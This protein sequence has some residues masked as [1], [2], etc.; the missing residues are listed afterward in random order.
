MPEDGRGGGDRAVAI[1]VSILLAVLGFLPVSSWIRGG[2]ADRAYGSRLIEWGYGT[3]ICLGLAI[4]AAIVLHDRGNL[5]VGSINR[6]RLHAVVRLA[7]WLIAAASLG[8]YSW[9]AVTVFQGR[10]L[11]IDEI[12]QVFQAR[13]FAA[14]RITLPVATHREFFSALNIVDVG[15]RMYSQFPPGGP[16]MLALGEL[17]HATWLVGPVCGAI[18]VLLFAHV[19]RFADPLASPLFR[20]GSTLLFAVAPFGAFMF[21]SHMNHGTALMWLLLAVVAL[22]QV[23]RGSAS[24]ARGARECWAFTC[25]FGLGAAAAIRP[26]DAFAFALPAAVWLLTRAI[27]NRREVLPL[28]V[29]G[30]GVAIPFMAMAAVNVASTGSPFLFG[31]EVLWGSAHGLGFHSAPWGVEHTPLRGIELIS[32]YVTRLQTFLFETPF[33]SLLPAILSLAL[34]RR[35]SA[36]DRYLLASALFLGGLYFAYWHDGFYLG[37]RFVFAWLPVLVLFTARLPRLVS[38]RYG[39]G[40]L[41]TGTTAVLVAGALIAMTTSLPIRVAQYRAVL[42]SMRTDYSAEASRAGVHDALVFVRESWG[43]QLTARMWARGI[44][45]SAAAS[46]YQHIDACVLDRAIRALELDRIRGHAAELRMV[47]LQRDSTRVRPSPLSPD[48]TEM[49]LPGAPYDQVC[50][51]RLNEDRTGYAHLVPLLLERA[52]GNVYARD[53]Q[54]RN[55]AILVE[56]PRR[57]VYLLRRNGNEPGAPNQW[58]PLR[59]ASLT[60]AWRSAT[61]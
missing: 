25:G 43:A 49:F 42:T 58:L 52:S 9:I 4:I 57:T 37:P 39:A 50:V 27:Q 28:L 21:G 23:T 56:Y 31:Y 30:L 14:G 38:E 51:S 55:S 36:L 44:S 2:E 47:S 15:G 54:E 46:F 48:S 53:L 40:R 10:P 33:P 29:S 7:P 18:S 34:V 24:G 19:Q 20:A 1:I 17:V 6:A 32:L 11:L 8:L 5:V 12:A 22:A 61:P 13:I 60:A 16:A 3:S 41:S 59:R 35:L 45:R 26:L